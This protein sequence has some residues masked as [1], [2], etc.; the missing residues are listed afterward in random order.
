MKSRKTNVIVLASLALVVVTIVTVL[1]VRH[2]LL[3]KDVVLLVPEGWGDLAGPIEVMTTGKQDVLLVRRARRAL[4]D[5]QTNADIGPNEWQYYRCDIVL[6]DVERIE[7][8]AWR[9]EDGLV[10]S[11]EI[12]F[13]P[14]KKIR[15]RP[16]VGAVLLEVGDTVVELTTGSYRGDVISPSGR[17]VAFMTSDPDPIFGAALPGSYRT[18]SSKQHYCQVACLT[19]PV[20]VGRALPIPMVTRLD[21]RKPRP[22]R[23]EPKAIIWSADER[24]V[25]YAG[26]T[27]LCIVRVS[28]DED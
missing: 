6:R 12:R 9:E 21:K 11:S 19:D 13:D 23:D 5:G 1:W 3:M 27:S 26:S 17:L 2:A 7:P 15:I 20:T 8:D 4:E 10:G 25:V 18:G 22:G 28:M 16:V 24:F 14:I